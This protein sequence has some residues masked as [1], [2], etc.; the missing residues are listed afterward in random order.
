MKEL[1]KLDKILLLLGFLIVIGIF[2]LAFIIYSKGG[3]CVINPCGYALS[4][5]ISCLKI[6]GYLP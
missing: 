2:V 6:Q 4:K 1:T 5:N 3:D